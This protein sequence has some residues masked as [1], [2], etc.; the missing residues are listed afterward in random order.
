[1]HTIYVLPQ[2]E[3]TGSPVISAVL[4][5]KQC[6]K[7]ALAFHMKGKTKLYQ[8]CYLTDSEFFDH[9]TRRIFGAHIE[10]FVKI[11]RTP[12]AVDRLCD[13][14]DTMNKYFA[15]VSTTILVLVYCHRSHNIFVQG[16]AGPR[17][18]QCLA[19]TV[20]FLLRK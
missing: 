1:M 10:G 11:P 12:A 14:E 4:E 18:E 3:A 17:L 13:L 20:E 8:P 2:S 16:E 6:D 19:E 15:A 5:L 7:K 9:T